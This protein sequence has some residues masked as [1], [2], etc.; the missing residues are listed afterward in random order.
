MRR[1]ITHEVVI[2]LHHDDVIGT[3]RTT[4][5]EGIRYTILWGG[6]QRVYDRQVMI[7]S[8]R[9]Q[10]LPLIVDNVSAIRPEHL[11]DWSTLIFLLPLLHARVSI[12]MYKQVIDSMF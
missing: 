5:V 6:K 4:T 12:Y 9:Q 3:I 2:S 1:Y 11:L 10:A 7:V 8:K